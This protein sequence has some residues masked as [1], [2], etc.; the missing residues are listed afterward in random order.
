MKPNDAEGDANPAIQD[1]AELIKEGT[2][3]AMS[4]EKSNTLKEPAAKFENKNSMANG[5]HQNNNIEDSKN[6][7]VDSKDPSVIVK[8]EKKPN[9]EED[10]PFAALDWKDGIATLPGN[11]FNIVSSIISICKCV[12]HSNLIC[13]WG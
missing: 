11:Y 13:L 12:S 10:D 8:K 1:Q 5:E 7:S 3:L 6:T 9:F 4:S 2:V